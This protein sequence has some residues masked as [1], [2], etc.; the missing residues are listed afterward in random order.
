MFTTTGSAS[1]ADKFN[2]DF[3][4]QVELIA[5]KAN[6]IMSQGSLYNCGLYQ[7]VSFLFISIAW[8]IGNGWYA[9]VS[10]FSGYTP[11]HECDVAS[12]GANFSVDQ[13]D[14]KCSALHV[15]TNATV[16]CTK[17]SYDKSQLES[18]IV[19]EFDFVC[20]KNYYCELAYSI[21]QIGYIVGTLIFSYLADVIG[22]KP[23]LVSVL[24]SMSVLGLAQQFVHNFFV[25]MGMGFVINSLACVS[26]K[27]LIH[28]LKID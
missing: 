17:W 25:F 27:M 6:A 15:P 12:M 11:E 5:D 28:Q 23:V 3:D 24:I 18:T 21:E 13:N 4:G 7:I 19:T 9:Y 26:V 2:K 8:T 14:T 22:R 20:D 16:K 10:V 1:Y